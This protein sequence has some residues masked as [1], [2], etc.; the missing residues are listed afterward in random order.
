MK[1]LV[2]LTV[3][4]AFLL[5]GCC[6]RLVNGTVTKSFPNCLIKA[7]A[8]ICNPPPEVVSLLNTANPLFVE[9]LNKLIPGT[10][11]YVTVNS[12]AATANKIQAG[13]CVLMTQ[14]D[15]LISYL[16]TSVFKSA[17]AKMMAKKATKA[18]D[19]QVLIN[20]KVMAAKAKK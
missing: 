11:E 9:I 17:E 5:C 18:T 13:G 2:V 16:Q 8:F 7:E 12:V 20:W 3:V 19:V 15:A 14:L 1:K 10:E 6:E 4:A